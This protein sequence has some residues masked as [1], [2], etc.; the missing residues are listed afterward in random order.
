MSLRKRPAPHGSKSRKKPKAQLEIVLT[1]D[2]QRQRMQDLLLKR[3][4]EIRA[5][6]QRQAVEA[7]KTTRKLL[8]KINRRRRLARKCQSCGAMRFF[9][10]NGD[11]RCKK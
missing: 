3:A 9:L 8:V 10:K 6:R 7:S 4:D 11:T 2:E 5:E 1:L